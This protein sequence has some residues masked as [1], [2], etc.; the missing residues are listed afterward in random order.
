MCVVHTLGSECSSLLRKIPLLDGLANS[1]PLLN[2][3]NKEAVPTKDFRWTKLGSHLNSPRVSGV[4]AFHYLLIFALKAL[5]CNLL[6]ACGWGL[7]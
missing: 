6:G 5:I 3:R 1:S 2:G 4:V 7:N